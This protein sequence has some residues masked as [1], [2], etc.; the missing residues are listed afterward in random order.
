MAEADSSLVL[1]HLKRIQ[2][3]IADLK[4]LRSEMREGFASLRAH[5]AATHSDLS[6]FERR[7][8]EVE[9]DMERAKRRPDLVDD[10]D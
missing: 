5:T 6:I 4:P 8:I 3:D 7:V 10:G 9:T 2:E 1:E